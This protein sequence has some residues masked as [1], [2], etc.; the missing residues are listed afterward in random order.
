MEEGSGGIVDVGNGGSFGCSKSF[1]GKGKKISLR[2]RCP[3][4]SRSR[5]L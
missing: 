1:W 4:T 3:S 5:Y 2:M